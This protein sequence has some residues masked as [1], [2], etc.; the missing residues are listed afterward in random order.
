MMAGKLRYFLERDGR[1]FARLVIPKKLRQYFE[2]KTELREALGGDRRAAER[3]LHAAV[4]SLKQKITSVEQHNSITTSGAP[5]KSVPNP[6]TV[7]QMVRQLY[8]MRL[9]VDE[10]SRSEHTGY[11]LTSVNDE[12]VLAIRDGIAGKLQ[13]H[14]LAA[15]VGHQIDFF[16]NRGNTA[17]LSGTAEWRSLAR[18]LCKAELEALDRMV[19]RDEGDYTGMP[20]LP[21]L[22]NDIIVEN[23]AAPVSIRGIFEDYISSRQILGRGKEAEKRWAPVFQKFIAHLGHN[24][25]SKV[26][27]KDIIAWRDTLRQNLSPSTISKVYLTAIGTAF[28]W[29]VSED[30]L[31]DNP[32]K[33]VRQETPKHLKVREKGFTKEE[34]TAILLFCCSY[35]PKPYIGGVIRELPET[36]AAKKWIPLLSAYS[37]ARVTE[38]T[39]LRTV[40]IRQVGELHVMRITPE[41]GTVKT[42]DYRDVPIHPALVEAGFIAFV[43]TARLG[44]L[45]VSNKGKG[46]SLTK[47]RT[48]GN[49]IGEWLKDAGL[50]PK[51]VSPNH[52]WRHRFKTVARE[53][54]LSD[55]II[56]AICGHA[57]RTAGDDYGDVTVKAKYKVI[58][59]MPA[60]IL[61][62]SQQDRQTTKFAEST[63]T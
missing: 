39:Q 23:G 16:R 12:L 8:E 41:A 31:K 32:A 9:D 13:D 60:Y 55:R 10:I 40:D 29:A 37:G 56:D 19:E 43:S 45:F 15:L 22:Q 34:A 50:V 28:N 7:E 1:Y 27:K 42:G 48:V 38:L 21:Y 30:R 47:A 2:N 11:E 57:G 14:T 46:D 25:A 61:P 52:G 36:S 51:G 44:P 59:A 26:T 24:D 58:A 4:A 54:G 62:P 53:E 63:P 49:R 17:A 20:N 5:V 6:L 33:D 35:E 18:E 3:K